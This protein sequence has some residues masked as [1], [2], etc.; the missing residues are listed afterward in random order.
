MQKPLSNKPLHCCSSLGHKNKMYTGKILLQWKLLRT[1]N[2]QVLA[3]SLLILNNSHYLK[4][5]C[6]KA[7]SCKTSELILDS[8]E[9]RQVTFTD[10]DRTQIVRHKSP[11]GRDRAEEKVQRRVAFVISPDAPWSSEATLGC[12]SEDLD[13]SPSNSAIFLSFSFLIWKTD[14]IHALLFHRDWWD[15]P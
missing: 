15:I 6:N 13:S 7:V 3:C 4:S 1:G 9:C 10:L 11:A 8:S 2:C 5:Y 14:I 12:K